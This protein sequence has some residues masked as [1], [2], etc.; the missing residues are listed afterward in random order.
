MIDCAD[1]TGSVRA[2]NRSPNGGSGDADVVAR[3][4]GGYNFYYHFLVNGGTD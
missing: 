1:S 2:A 4:T 3:Q